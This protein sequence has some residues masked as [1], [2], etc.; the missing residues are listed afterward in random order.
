MVPRYEPAK[1][2][3]KWQKAWAKK[4]VF[5]AKEGVKNKYYL[6]EMFPYP[7]GRIHMGHVRNYAIGDVV[8]RYRMHRGFNVLHPMG[9]DAFGLPAENAAIQHNTHPRKWT[10]DNMKFMEKQFQRLGFSIDWSRRVIT[11]DPDYYK[12]EQALFIRMYEKGLAYRKRSVVHWCEKCRTVL[13][14]EQVKDGR[15][16]R[17]GQPVV[18]RDLDQWFFKITAYAEELLAGLKELAPTWPERVLTM[19]RNW[20]GRSEGAL[21]DFEIEEFK[22]ERITVFTTRADTLFGATFLSI[23]PEHPLVDR[24]L[25]KASAEKK[26]EIRGFVERVKN[27]DVLERTSETSEKEGV[28]SGVHVLHPF[29]Q[30]RLPVFIANFVVMEY[31]TGAVMAVPCHDD[32]D[33]AF[34][35]KYSLHRRV[36]IQP[37]NEELVR[38][39]MDSAYTGPGTLVRS[40]PF[41]GL[42]SEEGAARIAKVLQEKKLGKPAI[43]YRLRDWGISR[44]RYWGTPIPMIHCPSCGVVPV[45][46]KDLPVK[47]PPKVSFTG[48]G[49]PPLEQVPSFVNIRCPKCKGKARRDTDTMDTFVE[50]SWYFLRYC[51]PKHRKGMFETKAVDYWLPV[52]QY[53]GGIEHAILHLLYTRFLIRVLRDFKMVH[54]SEPFTRLLTQ[55]MVIKDG[56]KM[57]KSKGNVVD[58]DY[59]IEKYGADTVRLFSLF[60]APVER[61]LDWSD[62]GVDGAYRFLDRLWRFALNLE[63]AC[64]EAAK[65]GSEELASDSKASKIHRLTQKTIR[66][67]TEC[68]DRMHFNVAISLIMELLNGVAQEIPEIWDL[69]S[70]P[71]KASSLTKA[72]RWALSESALAAIH[73]ISPFAP[74]I[75]DELWKRWGDKRI[76]QTVPWPTFDAEWAKDEKITVVV[77][78]NGKVRGKIEAERGESEERLIELAQKDENVRKHTEGK[79]V[80]R[81]IVVP[82][83]LVNL[84]VG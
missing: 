24:I 71:S 67:V 14:N 42:D 2:E 36:V 16:W 73:L 8:A 12:W 60:A 56:E 68:L 13:A 69:A 58:P 4:R 74:H 28:A 52:D 5:R 29:T 11:C 9:F 51:S 39:E 31:G 84:V 50:S 40:G 23:A 81:T 41:D 20:I 49:G 21:I 48:K 53:I 43:T 27:T 77:Q 38:E 78:V 17:C 76:L 80:R 72:Q 1:I 79:A 65:P 37:P 82:D 6:L 70:E 66:T 18:K 26:E 83:K 7:S 30:A 15:C 44:Q 19:Q 54:F 61:D 62:Q 47:L 33:F 3:K 46:L 57:S 64:K 35:N 63:S 45:P 75:A 10:Y 34:A 25:A 55:G 32:R 22:G 59:L